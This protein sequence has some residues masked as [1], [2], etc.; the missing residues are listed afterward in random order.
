MSL[1]AKIGSPTTCS[2][3]EVTLP[4]SREKALVTERTGAAYRRC[5]LDPHGGEEANGRH[6]K[7]E[8]A[9]S[10]CV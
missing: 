4:W 7:A 5:L 9:R 1:S 8:D 10:P 3:K 2:T 6:V